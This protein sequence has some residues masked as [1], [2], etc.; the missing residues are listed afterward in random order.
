MNAPSDD[1]KDIILSESALNLLFGDEDGNLFIGREPA[2]PDNCISIFDTPGYGP[3][4]TL[5]NDVN[6]YY[7][8]IQIRVRN[9]SYIVG[10]DLIF[11][12]MKLLHGR[13]PEIVNG[14]VYL[15]IV[16]VGE[17]TL[18]DWDANNRVRFICNFN[19]MRRE[20]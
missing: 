7:P 15:A 1:I 9:K 19:L 20:A 4:L 12:I 8:S 13:G 6:L 2:K 11:D 16:C 3:A 14:M 17:P 18:L 5:G 10:Y